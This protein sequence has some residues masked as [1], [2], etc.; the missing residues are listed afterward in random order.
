MWMVMVVSAVLV[1]AACAAAFGVGIRGE[2][3]AT[4]GYG[5]RIAACVFTV[6]LA[7]TVVGS[8]WADSGAFALLLVGVPILLAAGS[9]M[10]KGNGRRMT[11]VLWVAAVLMLGWALLTGLGLGMFFLGPAI[12]MLAAATASTLGN[13]SH[14]VAHDAHL[15]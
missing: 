6:V 7:L 14:A 10:A 11:A 2:S 3:V 12:V 5:L 1:A 9:L 13:Q 8:A 15:S 4:V